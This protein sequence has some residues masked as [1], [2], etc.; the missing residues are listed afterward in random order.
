[1]VWCRDLSPNGNDTFASGTRLILV[2][3]DSTKGEHVIAAAENNYHK[4]LFAADGNRIVF[5]RFSER[6]IFVVNWDGTGMR[7][8]ADGLAEDVWQDPVTGTNWVYATR[9]KAGDGEWANS[10]GQPVVRFA[11][12][13]PEQS[14][15]VWDATPVTTDNFQVSADGTRA[16][17]LFPHPRAG[18]VRLPRGSITHVTR[19]CWTSISPDTR[20]TIWVFDGSHRNLRF[21]GAESNQTWET[22]INQAPGIDGYEVY[23][24]RWSNHSRYMTMT[25]PYRGG[26]GSNRIG[27]GGADVEIYLG[28]FTADF[29]R[30]EE[31]ARI[32]DNR[33]PDFYPDAWIQCD[34]GMASVAV[35]TAVATVAS[36]P[37]K[38]ASSVG[39]VE[40]E[41]RILKVT[42]A[43]MPEA[44]APYTRAFVVH[45]AEV[46]RTLDG[47]IPGPT[48]RVAVWGVRDNKKLPPVW[49]EGQKV[50]LKL[51]PEKTKPQW[52]GERLLDDTDEFLLPLYF[53]AGQP[54]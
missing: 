52:K 41:V 4:P 10:T 20:F 47:K 50:T 9:E 13:R 39:P 27:N 1:L 16:V 3:W 12:D 18:V 6:K 15:I 5:S 2:G 43:P 29:T 49:R 37:T 45:L 11:I 48:L 40:V 14:E 35:S 54:D 7:L 46:V 25:G 38:G 51:E 30:V 34:T 28:R 42:A 24:P 21:F 33:F 32:T 44:I 23:H 31:W 22:C 8:L 26:E 36:P 17:G 53:L 19:G